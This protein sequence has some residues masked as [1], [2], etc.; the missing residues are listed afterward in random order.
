MKSGYYDYLKKQIQ[1]ARF[2]VP[3][4]DMDIMYI[5]EF[6]KVLCELL[7]E[8]D[9]YVSYGHMI[10]AALAYFVIPNDVIP[11]DVYGAWGYIDDMYICSAVLRKIYV[12]FPQKVDNY[13]P[14]T[15][16]ISKVLEKTYSKSKKMLEEKGLREK[17]MNFS[18]MDEFI[19]E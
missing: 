10:N 17:V 5:P 4:F 19:T 12:D 1:D 2:D 8:E 11:E 15:D 18:G 9:V 13:W 7:D 3:D 16:E 14:L 6:F